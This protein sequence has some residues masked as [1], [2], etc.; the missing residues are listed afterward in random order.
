MTRIALVTDSTCDL[1]PQ[2]VTTRGITVVPLTVS[3]DG[4]DY[5]DGVEITAAEFYAKLTAQSKTG[6]SQ[7]TP[8][9]FAQ[10]YRS[11]LE[12]HDRVFSMHISEGL[13]GT[14]ASAQQ[15][16]AEVGEGRVR[17]VDSEV[18]SMALGLLCLV[19]ADALAAGEGLDATE[20]EVARV[21]DSMRAYFTVATLEHLRR[22]GRIGRATEMLGSVLQ[23]KPV[24]CLAGGEV[25]PLERVRTRGR[26][27]AR[28]LELVRSV[29][30]GEGLCAIVAH[31]AAEETAEM[32]AQELEG[33]TDTLMVQPLGPVVGAHAGP[34]TVGVACYPAELHRLGLKLSSSELLR[35]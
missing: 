19:A 4:H 14:L 6:T 8:A 21:R 9:L 26:A 28:V 16:A 30:R 29:D 11:L 35:R 31:A 25:A 32:F 34:G 3:L 33:V 10:A 24:L 18:V 15:A 1:P 23:F 2:L 27:L 7:P 17:V 13:S 20:A 5:K 12:D 22:G